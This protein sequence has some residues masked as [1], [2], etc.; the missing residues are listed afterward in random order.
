MDTYKPL[1]QIYI[2]RNRFTKFTGLIRAISHKE[3]VYMYLVLEQWEQLTAHNLKKKIT[4][5]FWGAGCPHHMA[6]Q[7]FHF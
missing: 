6:E 4:V 1:Q 5:V 7:Q 2:L 3:L